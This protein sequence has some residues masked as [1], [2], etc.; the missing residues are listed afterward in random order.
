MKINTQESLV[1]IIRDSLKDLGLDKTEELQYMDIPA[2]GS[3]GDYSSNIALR[4]SRLVGKAP[5]EIA[6]AIS[7]NIKKKLE[8][9][10]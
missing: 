1:Y 10:H 4:L 7:E 8:L 3:F 9:K 2:E 6:A 5:L